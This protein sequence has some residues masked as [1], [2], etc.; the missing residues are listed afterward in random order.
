MIFE[1]FSILNKV[2]NFTHESRETKTVVICFQK[3][4]VDVLKMRNTSK[5]VG[6]YGMAL[7]SQ[8]ANVETSWEVLGAVPRAA[9]ENNRRKILRPCIMSNLI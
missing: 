6:Y 3:S 5:Y 4:I 8:P 9:P 2:S 7:V 1:Q